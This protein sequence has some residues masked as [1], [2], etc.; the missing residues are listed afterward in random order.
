[1]KNKSNSLKKNQK[2]KKK[3]TLKQNKKNNR[4]IIPCKIKTD[5]MMSYNKRLV[6]K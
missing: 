6:K 3:I 1:M 2:L 5:N 4:T